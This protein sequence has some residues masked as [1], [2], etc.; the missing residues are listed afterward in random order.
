MTSK[1]QKRITL[2]GLTHMMSMDNC[3]AISVETTKIDIGYST[4]KGIH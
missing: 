3:E 1:Y 2:S 4:D